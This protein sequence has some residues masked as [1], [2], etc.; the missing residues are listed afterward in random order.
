MDRH[1]HGLVMMSDRQTDSRSQD[2]LD[3]RLAVVIPL[4]LADSQQARAHA[5][6]AEDAPNKA[7]S[8]GFAETPFHLRK[9]FVLQIGDVRTSKDLLKCTR[10]PRRD[11]QE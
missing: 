11:L 8:L 9:Q 3:E 2:D 6:V 1:D 10:G 7:E 5:A 4:A